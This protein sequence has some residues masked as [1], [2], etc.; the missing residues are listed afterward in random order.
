MTTRVIILIAMVACV[1]VKAQAADP[2]LTLACQGTTTTTTMENAK[3][4]P[5][6]MGIILDFTKR[7]VQGFSV[8]GFG[9]PRLS[10]FSVD[11]VVWNDVKVVFGG[12]DGNKVVA[13]GIRGSMD[14]V[15][16][17]LDATSTVQDMK[18]GKTI[19]STHYVLKCTPTQR[20]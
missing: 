9:D 15:T 18:T 12:V 14:R 7:T 2:T 16:G 13:A 6:S 20:M 8:Q 4:E 17:D 11:I 1:S 5:I 10:D 3:P 19:T